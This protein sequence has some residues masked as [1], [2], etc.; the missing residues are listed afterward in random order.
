MRTMNP[1][2]A[3]EALRETAR[4]LRDLAAKLDAQADAL[5]KPRNVV[6]GPLDPWKW[7]DA[8]IDGTGL[9]EA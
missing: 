3:A 4:E 6:M 1:E 2:H 9:E 8:R 7:R 5:T